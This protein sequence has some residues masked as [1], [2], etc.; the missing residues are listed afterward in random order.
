MSRQPDQRSAMTV[1]QLM[2]VAQAAEYLGVSE[3]TVR[4]HVQQRE[5]AH[6][7]IGIERGAIRFDPHDLD[8]FL[9]RRKT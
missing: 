5:I 9:D 3:S 7:R 4:K 2:T 8:E 6:Y 1:N